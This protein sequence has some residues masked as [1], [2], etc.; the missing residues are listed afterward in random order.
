MNVSQ[1]EFLRMLFCPIYKLILHCFPLSPHSQ[2]KSGSPSGSLVVNDEGQETIASASG[3]RRIPT[4]HCKTIRLFARL[5]R[6]AND[7][8]YSRTCLG[9]IRRDSNALYF[10][11]FLALLPS[12]QALTSETNSGTFRDH[13]TTGKNQ[14]VWNLIGKRS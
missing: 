12:F 9:W 6:R 8:H 1:D 7:S 2:G 10:E 4:Q 14:A 5:L 11:T 3:I 13:R